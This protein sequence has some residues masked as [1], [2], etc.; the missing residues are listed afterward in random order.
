M[1]RQELLQAIKPRMTEKRYIH[2]VGVMETAIKL[3]ERFGED[4]KRAEVAAIIHDVCKYADINWMEQ[5]VKEQSLDARLL[6]WGS[7]LLHGPVG[8]YVAKNEF[9]V[10]DEGI[11]DAI[12]YHTTGRSGMSDLE[13]IVFIADMIEPNRK[14]DGVER[15]RDKAK[16]DLDKA[17]SAC[18][19]HSLAYLI[20]TKQPVFPVS[21]ECYNDLMNIREDK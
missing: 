18:I 11:L 2:T 12:R 4:P 5:V 14:F 16:K 19:Q 8:A 7:E 1:D 6:G 20:A 17:M 10:T 9:G 13:K 21:L 15:L 3:A